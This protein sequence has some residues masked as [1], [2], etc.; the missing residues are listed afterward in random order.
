MTGTLRRL[1]AGESHGKALVGILDGLPRGIPLSEK[2]FPELMHLRRAGYG[3]S[4]RHTIEQDRVEILSGV[5]FGMTLGSP[6]A[7][8]ILNNDF[9]AWEKAMAVEGPP[10][11]TASGRRVLTI[12]A[13][14][15]AD[16]AGAMKYDTHD[17]R[18][19]R[20]RASARETAMQVALSVPARRLLREVGVTSLAFVTEIGGIPALIPDSASISQL[21]EALRIAGEG[22]LT[23]DSTVAQSWKHL[24]DEARERGDTLG[25][26]AEVRCEG[27][28]AGLGSHA[29]FDRRLDARLSAALMAIPA[30]RAVEIGSG[31][32]QSR[33]GGSMVQ[34]AL[35]SKGGILRRKTNLAG[36]IEGGMTNGEPLIMRIYMKPLPSIRGVPSVDI[37]SHRSVKTSPERTDTVAIAAAAVVAESVLALELASALLDTFG[38]DTL[39]YLHARVKEARKRQAAFLR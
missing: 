18:D 33:S 28:V 27:L 37:A 3:R 19:I 32:F 22:F 21:R 23:P 4:P 38:G 24:I 2:D 25:G 29:Q 5:R 31:I 30:I 8:M 15:H 1:T 20:E 10:P 35:V 6:L 34:D 26:V 9:P 17:L 11:R 14:G 12:P 13:P 39:D 16:L 36:G 7:L